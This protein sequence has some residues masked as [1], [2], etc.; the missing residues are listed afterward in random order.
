LSSVN[1]EGKSLSESLSK[2]PVFSRMDQVQFKVN[3]APSLPHI[4]L[5]WD[6]LVHCSHMN[7]GL[8]ATQHTEHFSS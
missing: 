1:L 4:H 6:A 5:A 8:E 7:L 3:F 2:Q